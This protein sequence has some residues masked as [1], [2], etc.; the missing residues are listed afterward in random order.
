M[1]VLDKRVVYVEDDGVLAVYIPI[2]EKRTIEQHIEKNIPEG[3]TYYIVDK[4]EIPTDR[5]FR[6]AWTYTE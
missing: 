2:D 4:S 5:S 6:N 1:S 3:K